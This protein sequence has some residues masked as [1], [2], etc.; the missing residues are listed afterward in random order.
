MRI[1]T[2][3]FRVSVG[4]LLAMI[5]S[6]CATDGSIKRWGQCAMIGGGTGGILGAIESSGAAAGGAAAGAILGGLLCAFYPGSDSDGDGVADKYDT[7]P[8]TPKGEKVDKDGCPYDS[9]NDGVPDYQDLCE[10][11]PAGV[12]VNEYGCPDSDMDGVADN[13]DQCPDTPAG[14]WVDERGCPLD[15]DADG[16]PD[17]IDRC[18]NTPAGVPVDKYG[19]AFES[20]RKLGEVYF[21]FDKDVL[22]DEARGIL[23]DLSAQLLGQKDLKLKL[24]GYTDDKG[25][26][27]YNNDLSMRRAVSVQQYLQKSLGIE[28]KDKLEPVP[29]G[30]LGSKDASMKERATYRKVVIFSVQE[31]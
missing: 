18:P 12:E 20:L 21:S 4:M 23:D 30:A 16:I 15:S 1:P 31:Y 28:E 6:G 10:N 14:A 5:L 11:T 27:A 25:D 2:S 9:D 24:F 19:C 26:H 3:I 13:L 29:E 7:C 17:G 8:D 22:T